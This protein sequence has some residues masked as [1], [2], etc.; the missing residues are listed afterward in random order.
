MPPRL[1]ITISH[2]LIHHSKFQHVKRRNMRNDSDIPAT[3]ISIVLAIFILLMILLPLDLSEAPKTIQPG[4][5]ITVLSGNTVIL[6]GKPCQENKAGFVSLTSPEG[7]QQWHKLPRWFFPS[8]KLISVIYPDG[9][10]EWVKESLVVK[11]SQ[12]L[13]LCPPK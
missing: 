7:K 4:D 10:I 8:Y 1:T 11:P 6:D 2:A 12:E 9:T 13:L 3:L 5:K